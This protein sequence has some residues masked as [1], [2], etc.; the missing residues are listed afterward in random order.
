MF[1]VV[2]RNFSCQVRNF[3]KKTPGC[4]TRDNTAVTLLPPKELEP[5]KDFILYKN[6]EETIQRLENNVEKNTFLIKHLKQE[7]V[8][9]KRNLNK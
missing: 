2:T 6:F 9:I 1:R 5:S 8:E 3:T 7:I 4:Y